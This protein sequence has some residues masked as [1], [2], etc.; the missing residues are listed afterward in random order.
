MSRDLDP[1]E[2]YSKLNKHIQINFDLEGRH[3][4]AIMRYK[5]RDEDTQEEL[6][7]KMEIIRIDV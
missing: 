2:E 1:S 3:T 6:S 5:L 4:R 7:D